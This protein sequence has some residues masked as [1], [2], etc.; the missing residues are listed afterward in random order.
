[1]L[2]QVWIGLALSFFSESGQGFGLFLKKIRKSGQGFGLFFQKTA[3]P[4]QKG[5]KKSRRENAAALWFKV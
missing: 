1:M 2:R 4:G 3:K 5:Q